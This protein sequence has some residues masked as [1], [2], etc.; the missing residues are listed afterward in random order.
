M[1]RFGV[2]LVLVFAASYLVGCAS[3]GVP[4]HDIVTAGVLE[5]GAAPTDAGIE[6]LQARGIRTVVDLRHSPADTAR[7]RDRVT[8]LG[9]TYVNIPIRADQP[10]DAAMAQFLSIVLR[11][12]NQPVFVHCAHGRDRTGT[13]AAVYRIVVDQWTAEQAI[14]ELRDHEGIHALF[15]P[16]IRTYLR[17]LDAAKL[18]AR[19]QEIGAQDDS[20]KQSVP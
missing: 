4:N 9:M 18:Y 12:E 10:N 20:R 19:S 13:A 5:R 8:Q 3:S 11:P 7:E 15:F 17:H 6:T 14:V 16:E 1:H 2:T